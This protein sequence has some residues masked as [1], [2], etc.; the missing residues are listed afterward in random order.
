MTEAN[1]FWPSRNWA[2]KPFVFAL[3][4]KAG[5][6]GNTIGPKCYYVNDILLLSIRSKLAAGQS[7]RTAIHKILMFPCGNLR[8]SSQLMETARLEM[9]HVQAS[10][11]GD[12][13]VRLEGKLALET[14]NSFIQTMRHEQATHLVLD[15][16]GVSFLDSSGVGALVSLYVSRKH[17]GKSLAIARLTPQGNAVLQVSGVVK[18]IPTFAT[19]EEAVDQRW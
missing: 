2:G 16:S 7:L 15:M 4:I 5:C 11:N 17:S 8:Y 14:V 19:V 9:Q 3:P 12:L 13:V 18:L 6:A 10:Q 1:G